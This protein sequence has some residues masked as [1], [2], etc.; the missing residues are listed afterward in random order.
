MKFFF[1]LTLALGVAATLLVNADEADPQTAEIAEVSQI[2]SR[3]ASWKDPTYLAFPFYR[4]RHENF[5]IINTAMILMMA[6]LTERGKEEAAKA[7]G[8]VEAAKGVAAKARGKEAAW[9]E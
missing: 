7:R 9:E 5:I 4:I 6:I 2:R 8:K 1:L 3:D